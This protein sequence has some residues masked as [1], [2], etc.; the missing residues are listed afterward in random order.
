MRRKLTQEI[1]LLVFA[2]LAHNATFGQSV[3]ATDQIIVKLR[4][5][6]TLSTRSS[7]KQELGS[8]DFDAITRKFHGLNIS[9]QSIGK[10]SSHQFRIVKLPKGVDVKVVIDE[11]KRID[12]IEYVEPDHKGSGGGMH[13]TTPN[14]Q[15]YSRQW[16][17]K[18]NGTFLLS[19]SIAGADIEMENAWS[20]EQ[21]DTNIVV[22]I[23]DTGAKLD[24][25]E[26]IGRIWS[27]SHEIQNNGIDDDKN[28]FIDDVNGWDFANGDNDPADDF[29]HGTNVIG[30]IG[31][32]GDNSIGYS[33]VDWNCKLMVL[34]GLD[35]KNTGYY[36]WW[37]DAIHYA[38]DNGARV[39]NMSM[40]GVGTSLTLQNAINYALKKNV[41]VVAC[42][43]NTNSNTVYFPAGF[44]GVVAVGST[45]SNDKRTSSFF[46]S[47]TSG[48][49]FGSH[50]SVVAPGN[51]IY[52]LDYQSNTNYNNYWGGTSQAAPLVSGLASLLLAQDMSRTPSQIKS[53]I[54]MT[55]QD[56]IGSSSEDPRGWDQYY[57]RGRINAFRAL[58]AD[59]VTAANVENSDVSLFPNPTSKSFTVIFPSTARQIEIL[60]SL[61]EVVQR[62]KIDG[63]ISQ[64]FELLE[65]G[66]YVI[67]VIADNQKISRRVIVR[68]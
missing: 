29:G 50:I 24:H 46:W 2:A 59:G 26:F 57:G 58:S 47:T 56:Q 60:N 62:N 67:R 10:K 20:L 53:V 31:A 12:E 49:N 51:F 15:Y 48:S 37:S 28:G 8:S 23:I 21:G 18:N 55:A 9:G 1:A 39:I 27:N 11:Y 38:V 25:P 35:A 14:D 17:L 68:K 44:P 19:P 52:G 16:G 36:S 5:T 45:N 63:E 7:N 3:E 32:N 4:N 61:G 33:G 65:S 64:E 43:M 30:I 34:K 22:A 6:D 41:V 54:E 42:M 13:G 66:V 40:G